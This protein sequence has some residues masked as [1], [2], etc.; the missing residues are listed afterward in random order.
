[1]NTNRSLG[2]WYP[3]IILKMIQTLLTSCGASY[4]ET[5]VK[6][7][8]LALEST[9]ESL[10]TEFERIIEEFD[11][12]AGFPA[13]KF[14]R[15]AEDANSTIVLTAGL[16][17]RDGKVGWGQWIRSTET[18]SPAA[19]LSGDAPERKNIYS[20]RLEFDADYVTDRIYSRDQSKQY[21]I[22]KLVYHEVGHG[23]TMDHDPNVRN[24][25]Y[26]DISGSK[27]FDGFFKK[28]RD[29]FTE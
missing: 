8:S 24:V 23:L 19:A 6:E 25:M 21:D 5:N 9:D 11:N 16:N 4:K 1:M 14:T 22:K 17:A 27:D 29:F 20:M 18:E 3:F 2:F 13:L 7:Y 26:Y 28:V 10:Q 15:N 12:E